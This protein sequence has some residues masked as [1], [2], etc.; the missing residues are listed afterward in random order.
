MPSSLPARSRSS[1]EGLACLSKQISKLL[2]GQRRV[3][4]EAAVAIE[5]AT[6]RIVSRSSLRPDLWPTGDLK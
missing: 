3:S 6:D 1:R 4:A 5:R 2:N